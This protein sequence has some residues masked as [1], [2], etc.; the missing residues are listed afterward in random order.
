M[1]MLKRKQRLVA[2]AVALALFASLMLGSSAGLAVTQQEALFNGNF[3]SGFSTIPGCGVVGNG[4]GCFTNGGSVAYGFY[5][6][7]W[8]P[9][10]ADGAHSQLI[11]LNTMQPAAS[12]PDRYAGIYQTAN[13]VKGT[14][15]QFKLSGLMREALKDGRKPDPNDDPFRYRVQ[16]GLHHRW[17]Y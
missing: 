16:V 6:D 13:V 15:Y 3:E 12:E 2:I 8:A 17:C 10:R 5:D 1:K 9:V 14:S 4:W 7:Q 11:E